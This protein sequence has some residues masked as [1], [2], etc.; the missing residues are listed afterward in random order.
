MPRGRRAAIVGGV[1]TTNALIRTMRGAH[2]VMLDTVVALTLT[3]AMIGIALNP[4]S[5]ARFTGPAWVLLAAAAVIGLPVA[6]RRRWPLA[7][8]AVVA[9]A[10]V[11]STVFDISP[12]AYVSVALALYLVG[13]ATP[14][15]RSVVAMAASL[16][17]VGA[18]VVGA[19]VLDPPVDRA[20]VVVVVAL[21]WLVAGGMWALGRA[22]RVRR[23]YEA[24]LADQRSR[25]SL[26]DERMRIAREVH[27]IVAHSMSLIAARAG[28]ANHVAETRPEEARAALRLIE[29]TSRDALHDMRRVLGVMRTGADTAELAPAAGLASLTDLADH[30]RHAGVE[31]ELT[32]SAE[33]DGSS[34]EPPA[35]PALVAYRVVQESLTN[36]VKHAAPTRCRVAV[37][38]DGTAIRVDVT[39]DGPPGHS[40][41]RR[42]M[43]AGGHGLVGMRERV[44]M[45]GGA[46]GAGPCAGGGFAVS[47]RVPYER[48]GRDEG[49]GEP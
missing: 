41:A 40:P 36:V 19:A 37:V 47:A 33:G 42:P 39:D 9:A 24:R 46:F 15:R 32:V 7:V 43:P 11:V 35:G 23:A 6:V 21:A 8:L 26:T 22:V 49:E 45:Y 18:G 48:A 30:A 13:A 38:T 25:Q 29:S 20:N 44:E 5:T 16:V 14:G 1:A 28:I 3:G 27:D 31:V 12:L 10:A 17:A 4:G 34:S 2:L